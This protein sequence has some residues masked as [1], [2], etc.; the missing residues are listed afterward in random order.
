MSILI[1]EA[2][3]NPATQLWSSGNYTA[4]SNTLIGISPASASTYSLSKGGYATIYELDNAL[5]SDPGAY[6]AIISF[7]VTI[8]DSVY[9]SGST[10]LPIAFVI[11][12]TNSVGV[13][14]SGI[15]FFSNATFVTDQIITIT[16]PFVSD[17]SATNIP[18]NMYGI[19]DYDSLTIQIQTKSESL[20]FVTPSPTLVSTIF[21]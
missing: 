5:F 15:S 1:K 20:Q 14:Y 2:Y 19:S 12:Y 17:G 8:S 16:F 7:S 21:G 6:V 13:F 18:I 9:T 11:N 10:Y 4:P 3:A